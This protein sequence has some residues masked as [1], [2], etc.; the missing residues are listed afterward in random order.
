MTI[1]YKPI[2]F[3]FH[4]IFCL[5]NSQL[6]R[7]ITTRKII[8]EFFPAHP[9]TQSKIKVNLD[10]VVTT[11]ANNSYSE[12]SKLKCIL[13]TKGVGRNRKTWFPHFIAVNIAVLCFNKVIGWRC[14]NFWVNFFFYLPLFLFVIQWF[15]VKVYI[16]MYN[17]KT[18]FFWHMLYKESEI[19]FL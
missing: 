11:A 15:L 12:N 3:V 7:G 19:V 2:L 18:Y 13:S 14:C 5:P 10:Y 16:F 6:F 8:F 17:L 1:R 9:T 4:P